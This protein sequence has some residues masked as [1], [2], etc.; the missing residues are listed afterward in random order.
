ML[1][2]FIMLLNFLFFPTHTYRGVEMTEM[3]FQ[4]LSHYVGSLQARYLLCV[5]HLVKMFVKL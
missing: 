5:L 1:S 4:T 2:V 3:K